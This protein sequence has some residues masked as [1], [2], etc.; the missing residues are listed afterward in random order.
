MMNTQ[1]LIELV[2]MIKEATGGREK[3][4]ERIVASLAR[5]Q[6]QGIPAPEGLMNAY[7]RGVNK[8]L[9][10]GGATF[11]VTNDAPSSKLNQAIARG[12]NKGQSTKELMGP[13]GGMASKTRKAVSIKPLPPLSSLQRHSNELNLNHN[14]LLD[15]LKERRQ[16]LKENW[17]DA[18]GELAEN[19]R[20]IKGQRA[21]LALGRK[22]FGY[23]LPK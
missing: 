14:R 23:G 12:L 21:S 1:K 5:K 15:A 4:L 16:L 3:L 6:R 8:V 13:Y 20:Y 22:N 17:T 18:T 11:K 10:R 9:E 19:A 2:G 7:T